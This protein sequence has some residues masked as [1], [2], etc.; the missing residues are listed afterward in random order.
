MLSGNLLDF[1]THSGDLEAIVHGHKDGFLRSEEYNNLTQCDS[2]ADLKSQLQVTSYGNFLQSADSGAL[3]S[4]IVKDKATE[5]LCAD[6]LELRGWAE[7]ALAKFL[8]FI[9]YEFMIGNVLKLVL[10]GRQNASGG[11]SSLDL[12]TRCHPLG[13]FP[14]IATLTAAT[15][16]DEMFETVLVDSPIGRFFSSSATQRRDLDE[17]S[18]EYI[19]GVLQKNYLDAFYAMVIDEMGGETATVMGRVLEFEA[20]RL[21]LTVTCNTCGMKELLPADRR[22]LFPNFGSLVDFQEELSTVESIEQ[23]VER[24][25][26]S[27]PDY[28]ELFE[29]G[30]GGSLAGASKSLEKQ[31]QQMAVNVYKDAL[32]RQFQFGVFYGWVKLKEIE[33]QNLM[34]ISECIT[35]NMKNRVHEYTPVA[36]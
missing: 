8:D 13:L 24:L 25:K 34:W 10:G 32:S 26:H 6:F 18:I 30:R 9:Q 15:G 7:P 12:L 22:K 3:T 20:D 17:L 35:Q 1:N 31:F 5:K 27:H 2:L 16:I 14:G 36:Y 23:L 28:A 4:R 19:R 21:V 11:T 29:N 33:I